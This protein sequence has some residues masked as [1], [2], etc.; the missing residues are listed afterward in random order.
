MNWY[1]KCFRQY[2]DFE[3]RA[4]RKEFWMYSLFNFAIYAVLMLIAA[5]FYI[6]G[7][8]SVLMAVGG[9]AS[10]YSLA[11]LVPSL[12]VTFRRIHDTGRHGH[13][14]FV[15][16]IP[17]V[18]A[19]WF[20]IMLCQDSQ[21]ESN[22]W[23][24]NPKE[25][26]LKI[27]EELATPNASTTGMNFKEIVL[28]PLKQYADFKGRADKKEFWTFTFICTIVTNALALIMTTVSYFTRDTTW[29]SI[30]Y[31]ICAGLV[32][33]T[34]VP[35]LAVSARRLHDIGQSGWMIL[36]S[37]IPVAGIVWLV[38]LLCKESQTE[39]N[40]WGSRPKKLPKQIISDD[41]EADAV[42]DDN[43]SVA[44]IPTEAVQI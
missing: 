27:N 26:D 8:P 1:L 30:G 38:R 4:R 39:S 25:E 34:L 41:N 20:L 16:I 2:A 13:M 3:G 31:C 37:Q 21:P 9:L 15:W 32:L 23:G 43:S 18:G 33:A 11:T 28:K 12:A 17:V 10:L 24:K 5:A 22:N 6:N 35:F 42:T 19:I 44:E 36:V 40:K 7:Y 14:F 29:A